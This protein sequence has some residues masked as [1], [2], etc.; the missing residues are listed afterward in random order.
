MGQQLLVGFGGA[1]GLN[2]GTVMTMG[3]SLGADLE[4]L[5]DIL[6]QIEAAR[7]AG[8]DDGEE[9]DGDCDLGAEEGA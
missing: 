5:A 1:F 9:E 8:L 2:F 6:P 4:M 3:Q 7:L